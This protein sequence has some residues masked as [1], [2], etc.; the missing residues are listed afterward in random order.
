MKALITVFS[1]FF[2]VFAYS[3]TTINGNVVDQSL[4]PLLG[5]NI[6]VVGTST[7]TVTDFEGNFTLTVDL[8]PPFSIE[9]SNVGY[10]SVRQEV[11]SNNQSFTIT[12]IERDELDEIVVSASRAPES[13]WESPVTIERFDLND[14]KY[15][16]SPNFYASLAN[17]K[18]VDVNK[19]SLTFNSVNTRGFATYANTRF[20]QLIDG[21]DNS[22]PALNFV[23]GNFV[24]LNEL[25][26]KSIELLP[27]ASSALYGANAFNG[28]LFM[29]SKSPFNYQGISTYVKTGLT[30]QEAAG[31]NKFYDI[32]IRVARAFSD[33]FAAKASFSYLYGTDWHAIDTNQYVLGSSGDPDGI[34]PFRS[35]PAHDGLNIYGDEVSLSANDTN[36][37]EVALQLEALGIFPA[38]ASALIP[39]VDVA[40]TGYIEADL[41]DY[42]AKSGKL[43]MALHYKPFG[44][45]LEIIWISKFGF[46]NTVYTGADR[47][48]LTNFLLYQHKLEIRNNDFFLRGYTTGETAGNSYDMRFTGIN[49]SKIDATE[50]F[51]TYAG[52]YLT[53]VLGGASDADAHA[54]ARVFAD[55]AITLKPGTP[56]FIAAFNRITSDPDIET[57]SKF[58]DNSKVYVGE[59]N[60]NFKRVL[61]D[62]M[63]LQLGGSY[64][65]YSLNSS[66][67]IYTDY[68]GSID[69]DEYGA[70]IQGIKKFTDEERL[71]IT[72]SIR[73][74]K[75]E[76]FDASYSP[77]VSLLYFAGENKQHSIRASFQTGFRNPDTQSLFI[78]F[79]V[80][81]AILVGSAPDNLD[82]ILPGT[83]LTG[84]D[85][86]FDS[87]TLASV[88]AFAASGDPSLLIPVV[89]SLVEQEKVTAFDVGYRGKIGP[90]IIDVNGYYNTYDGFISN[91]FVVTPITGSAFDP[92]GSGIQDIIDGN[93]QVFQLYT[94]SLADVNSYGAAIGLSTKFVNNYRIGINYTFA[95]FDLDQTE[96][97]DF[98]AGFNTPENQVK[99]SFGNQE[100][101]ENFGFNVNVRWS[102]EYLWEASIANALVAERTVVDA[103]INYTVPSIKS[104][105][106][107]GGTNLGGKEYKSSVGV[108]DIGS[109][110][111]ISWTINN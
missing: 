42:K 44:N 1:L 37:H 10:Q 77:R 36:L 63:D 61:N 65:Q 16:T 111:F 21:M 100:L 9:I 73:Y 40:R 25:D 82:R 108:G 53:A 24:G 85:A 28:I 106:K 41:T 23:L 93:T 2:C 90:V 89:T 91:K 79:N 32:G 87:Y 47:Y 80:G 55:D 92:N 34:L 102:D 43:N 68:D 75:N 66:G 51:G 71:K 74:D 31:D 88:Q 7:G 56:E 70:Y 48:Q 39:A 49:M 46:G 58:L 76:F 30:I 45:D 59:G 109:Q 97:P 107:V 103:Q 26:V 3:Q 35:S 101:F 62:V 19:G 86:Y 50:W 29:T 83:P 52:A 99:F 78:G 105:F 4:E 96:D 15:S 95:Q 6:I 81:R 22:S 17:L 11:T 12:L 69:Y 104:I 5:T 33:K 18:G 38:G 110:F 27:G 98:R 20:V 13:V 64:R 72:A 67:T 8:A 57:G 54:G 94:N 14:I 60:Y 84:R